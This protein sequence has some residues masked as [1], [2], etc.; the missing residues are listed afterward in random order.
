MVNG[1]GS[2]SLSVTD[3]ADVY[4]P[5]PGLAVGAGGGVTSLVI[6]IVAPVMVP[7]LPARVRG[8]SAG[9]AIADAGMVAR[10]VWA[11]VGAESVAVTGA[12]VRVP[13][14]TVTVTLVASCELPATVRFVVA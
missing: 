7:Y 1:F 6:D 5:W 2:T 8:P 14:V 10:H 9:G 11:P 3:C 12:V 4:E 13:S